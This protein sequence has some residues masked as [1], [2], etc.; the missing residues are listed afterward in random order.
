MRGLFLGA[1]VFGV[2]AGAAVAGFRI[3]SGGSNE[4]TVAGTAT[5]RSDSAGA[6]ETARAYAKAWTNEQHEALYAL[7]APSAQQ[8]YTFA[9][10]EGEFG[11]FSDEMTLRDLTATVEEVRDGQ[12]RIGV[13]LKTAYFGDFEYTTRLNLRRVGSRW[14]IEWGPAAIHPDLAGG[15]QFH[16]T[17]ERP[18]RGTVFDRNGVALAITKDIRMV[19]LNR[20][21]ITDVAAVRAAL[22]AFGFGEGQVDAALKSAAGQNQ[23]VAVG[24]VPDE[25]A[26]AAAALARIA[27]IILYFETQRVHPLGA[28]AAHVVGYTREL[29]AEELGARKGEGFRAGD[30]T[31]AI[32]IE[33]AMESLLAGR[34]GVELA[35]VDATGA[36]VRVIQSRPFVAAADVMTTLDAAVLRAAHERLGERTGAAAVIDPVSNAILAINSSPSFDPDAFERGDRVALQAIASAPNSPQTNRATAGLYSAGSTFKLVTGA[37]GLSSGQFKTTDVLFC[38]A[39]WDGIDPPRKNWEGTQGPLTIAQGL[40]RSCN[41]VFYEIA[42]RLYN[43]ADGVLS[44][45]ARAFGFG[46]PTGVVGI[47]DEAGLVPDA[48]WKKAKRGESWFPGDEVNLGI[49]QGDLLVTPLQLANAYA[50][51][52]A[53]ALRTPVLLAG[54]EATV[55]NEIPLTAEQSAHLRLGLRLVTSAAGTASAAFANAGYTNFGG[56]SGTAED[57]GTQQHVLFV[58]YAPAAQPRAVAAVVLDEG[59]SGSIEAGPIARDIVLAALR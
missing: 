30:R 16:S 13:H 7:L 14:L 56:K 5:V 47:G 26:D 46:A 10:F 45:T 27:G 36:T 54:E 41:S 4:A 43:K 23:R 15:S 35:L 55:R 21:V 2:L 37:A 57:V 50:S 9:A 28:A 24:R 17:I 8:V 39:T 22:I 32:G 40:M 25:K 53:G 58:A 12:A 33:A 6:L 18:K 51:F 3:I 59:E 42:L 44:A 49:G 29:T 11:S 1:I 20:S 48:A 38:G 52:L 34:T 19:G 31:G